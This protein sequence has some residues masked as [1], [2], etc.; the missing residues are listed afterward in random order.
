MSSQLIYRENS[1][2]ADSLE[3]VAQNLFNYCLENGDWS[4]DF[5]TPAIKGFITAASQDQELSYN[6]S[7]AAAFEYLYSLLAEQA[8]DLRTHQPP[9]KPAEIAE[10]IQRF[11]KAM[12]AGL[13]DHWLV[14]PIIRAKL[15]SLIRFGDYIFIPEQFTREQKIR[16]LA[17]TIQID[18]DQMLIR[19]EH[20]EKTR[21][22]SFY[23]YTLM[24]RHLTHHTPWVTQLGTRTLQIDFALIRTLS[25]S[26]RLQTERVPSIASMLELQRSPNNHI[27]YNT[28]SPHNWGQMP[29]WGEPSS[30]T[31]IGSLDW[32]EDPDTQNQLSALDHRLGVASPLDRLAFRFQRAALFYSKAVDIDLLNRSR[33]FEGLA[34]ELLHLLIAA[35]TLLLDRE[36]EK[37]LRLATLLSRLV[38]L[39]DVSPSGVFSAIN[40]CY[41]WRS[42]YVHSGEDVFPEYDEEFNEGKTQKSL[43]L[44]RHVIARLIAKAPSILDFAA[45]KAQGSG[46]SNVCLGPRDTERA[47]FKYLDKIWF[48]VL[49]GRNLPKTTL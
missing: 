5:D 44:A 29:V 38:L 16:V 31:F 36:A 20:T 30:T 3:K 17:E 48:S 39:D 43:Y 37:R 11:R 8:E 13:T 46:P 28:S 14:M 25:Q 34:L 27:C 41:T 33:A 15:K 9:A 4:P 45:K 26:I 12:T 21:S 6:W 2:L 19:A 7:I 1:P 35:E 23:E 40:T 22:P 18:Y 42:D 24:C 47:W 10:F 49:S 32:L